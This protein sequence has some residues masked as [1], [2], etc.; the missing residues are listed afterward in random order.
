MR[1]GRAPGR[2][3]LQGGAGLVLWAM[4]LGHSPS[5]REHFLPML[6]LRHSVLSNLGA[7]PHSFFLQTLS[8][9]PQRWEWLMRTFSWGS[10]GASEI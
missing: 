5:L 7:I 1:V 2:T 4:S 9:G 6:H 8:R 10:G 3:E